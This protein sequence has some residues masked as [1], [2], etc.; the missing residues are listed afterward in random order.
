MRW[1]LTM[2]TT[3]FIAC[4]VIAYGAARTSYCSSC[5]RPFAIWRVKGRHLGWRRVCRRCFRQ[6]RALRRSYAR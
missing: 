1:T 6:H 3:L 2:L 4:A 5:Y